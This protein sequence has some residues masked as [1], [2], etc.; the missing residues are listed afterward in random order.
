[1]DTLIGMQPA[2][3]MVLLGGLCAQQDLALVNLPGITHVERNGHHFVDGMRGRR[4]AEQEAFLA[5]PPDLYHREGGTVRLRIRDGQL[6]IGSLDCV[7][8]SGNP[9]CSARST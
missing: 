6:S 8:S 2:P 3:D 9:L 1:M 5:G 4:Q 7:T